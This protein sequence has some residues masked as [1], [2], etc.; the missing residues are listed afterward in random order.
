MANHHP[1]A[2]REGVSPFTL[3]RE[4]P[5]VKGRANRVRAKGL[6]PLRI[7]PLDPK[8]SLATNYNTPANPTDKGIY[9]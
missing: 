7:T 8:S 3:A 6:E 2:G 5:A 1:G 9:F 4:S